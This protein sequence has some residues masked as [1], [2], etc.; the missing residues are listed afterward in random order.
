M[1]L[2]MKRGERLDEDYGQSDFCFCFC[3]ASVAALGSK[4]RSAEQECV[5]SW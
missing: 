1:T 4:P 3:S 5:C 2:M